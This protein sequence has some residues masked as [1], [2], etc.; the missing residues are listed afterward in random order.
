MTLI[1]A[2]RDVCLTHGIE[3]TYWV[4]YS[5]GLDSTVLLALCQALRKYLPL[6]LRAIHIHHGLSPKATHWEQ[7]CIAVCKQYDIPLQI[8]HLKLN[9]Y[10]GGSVEDIARI[11][12][13]D[14]FARCLQTDDV[15][16]TA[17]QQDDQA[18]TILLQLLRGAGPK[19]LA[20]MPPVKKLGLGWLARPLLTVTRAELEQ[21]ATV[22]Q[23]Q[24]IDDESNQNINFTRNFLRRQIVPVL[25]SRWPS[26]SNIICRSGAH[27]A[28][29]QQLVESFANDLMPLLQGSHP[30]TLSVKKLLQLDAARQ[31]LMLR[32]WIQ[33]AGHSLPSA[34]KMQAIYSNALLAAWDATPCITWSKT[35]VRRYRDDLFLLT[36]LIK[37]DT[38]KVYQWNLQTPLVVPGIG[39]LRTQR[40]LGKGLK[41]TM[42][43]VTICFRQ[44]G[45]IVD[46]GKR[47]HHALKNLFQEW[48][49]LP[50]ERRR[51]PLVCINNEIVAIAGYYLNENY[52]VEATEEG[53]VIIVDVRYST[54]GVF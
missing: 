43:S 44:G 32:M 49:V 16:L 33:Q 28:E 4:A 20:G 12:R 48:G 50:W 54:E 42:N 18:E 25:T 13:Y 46:L 47:G 22:A 34:K 29:A 38:E 35:E 24:W 26:V 8:E 41:T 23:L 2:V 1:D 39:V 19:G 3:K 17:H 30:H 37:H 5:G 52:V 36:P 21:Y 6:K 9:L 11:A 45:E 14:V 40:E 27:C 51:I 31:R 7:H 10:P 53:L 15:L